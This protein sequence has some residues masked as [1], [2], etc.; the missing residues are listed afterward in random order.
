M[1]NDAPF[2]ACHSRIDDDILDGVKKDDWN[3]TVKK[4]LKNKFKNGVKVGNNTIW[5][6]AKGRREF[7]FS[8]YAQK[9]FSSDKTLYMDKLRMANNADEIVKASRDYVNEGLKHIRKDGLRDFAKGT[10]NLRI[11]TNDYNAEVIIGNNGTRLYLYDVINLKKTV[12]KGRSNQQRYSTKGKVL[13]IVASSDNSISNN[14]ENDNNILKQSRNYS[15]DELIKKPDI[16]VPVNN[17]VNLLKYTNTSTVIQDSLSNLKKYQGVKYR[18]NNPVIEND[19]TGDK[20]QVTPKALKHGAYNRNAKSTIFISLNLGDAIKYG[21]KVN[22]AEGRRNNADSAYILMGRMD[23]KSGDK[24]YY[25]IAVNRY[26]ENNMGEYYIDDLYAVRAQKNRTSP[27]SWAGAVRSKNSDTFTSS[28]ISVAN[29]LSEIKDYYGNELSRDVNKHLGRVKGK[30]DIEG[31]LYQSRNTSPKTY[32]EALID[33]KGY[34]EALEHQKELLEMAGMQQLSNRGIE[35]LTYKLIKET[36]TI[37]S[38][39]ELK[40]S[41]KEVFDKA[42]DEKWERAQIVEEL[43]K[44]TYRALNEKRQNTKRTDYAQTILDELRKTRIRLTEDQATGIYTA[45]GIKYGDWRKSMMGKIIIT[46]NGTGTAL[47][48]KWEELSR[49]YPETFSEDVL[50]EDM[51]AELETIIFNLQNDYENDWGFD[52]EDV[53]EY[54]A[55]EVLAEYARLPEV[56][57]GINTEAYQELQ[58]EYDSQLGKVRVEYNKRIKEFRKGQL[59]G[60]QEARKQWKE[61]QRAREKALEERYKTLMN[62]RVESIRTRENSVWMTRDKEKLRNNIIKTVKRIN[63]LVVRP[64]NQKHA[65]QGFLKKTAE[66][67]QLFMNDTSVFSQS[68]LDNLKVAYVA[69]KPDTKDES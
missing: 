24:Y 37:L 40:G 55:T 69:L 7:I 12:I 50:P 44:V 42:A 65:P 26:N 66:F 20:I 31:L 27:A 18:K 49:L 8:K 33:N 3:E 14:F 38:K 2:L 23:D 52:F 10:V 28:K 16:S 43:K 13:N 39:D 56:K 54:C 36:K 35:R 34:N 19:D 59:R 67:C 41:V 62:N 22:E 9:I 61:Y 46:N 5:Q 47:D 32:D 11:G 51:P 29:F 58:E 15:Y 64:T 1:L 17:N 4:V 68:A 60:L 57:N 53:A 6:N 45:T 25:R 48:S 63:T 30:S 21:I